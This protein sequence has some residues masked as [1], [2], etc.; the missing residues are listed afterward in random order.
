MEQGDILKKWEGQLEKGQ[1]KC[2]SLGIRKKHVALQCHF[3]V[4]H[5]KTVKVELFMGNLIWEDS[6]FSM[7]IKGSTEGVS[8][9][10]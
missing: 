7:P 6:E 9:I 3:K 5:S 4:W 10:K 1:N 8:F 2:Y